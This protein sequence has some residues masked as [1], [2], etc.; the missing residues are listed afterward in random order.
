M[1]AGRIWSSEAAAH[2][3]LLIGRSDRPDAAR[4][5]ELMPA[6]GRDDEVSFGLVDGGDQR[7]DDGIVCHD[8]L[9]DRLPRRR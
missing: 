1:F 3:R 4:A 6:S 8:G 7:A 5:D 9:Q 2:F